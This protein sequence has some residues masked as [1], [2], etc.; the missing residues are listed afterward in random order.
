[1]EYGG[2]VCGSIDIELKVEDNAEQTEVKA[3]CFHTA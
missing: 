3:K 2:M 1:M